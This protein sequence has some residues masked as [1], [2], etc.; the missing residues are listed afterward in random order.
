MR[1][2]AARTSNARYSPAT[3]NLL[4]LRSWKRKTAICCLGLVALGLL[5]GRKGTGS[6]SLR[7]SREW[8]FKWWLAIGFGGWV[9]TNQPPRK[10]KRQCLLVNFVR[11]IYTPFPVNK[12]RL[13][14]PFPGQ[15]YFWLKKSFDTFFGPKFAKKFKEVSEKIGFLRKKLVVGILLFLWSIWN[16]KFSEHFNS[17][18]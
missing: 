6:W 13:E 17:F 4:P 3:V 1:R 5:V 11:R 15:S 2:A 14:P 16:L 18:S 12:P 7:T 10:K 9:A 8:F